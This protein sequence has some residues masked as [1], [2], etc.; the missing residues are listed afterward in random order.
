MERNSTQKYY[1]VS[2]L[3]M[4]GDRALQQHYTSS[5]ESVRF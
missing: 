3:H 4:D 1:L 2:D 5:H